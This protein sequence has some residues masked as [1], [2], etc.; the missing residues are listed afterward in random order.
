[1]LRSRFYGEG[2][3]IVTFLTRDFGKMSGIAKGA[4]K[5]K[6]RFV[7]SLEPFTHVHLAFRSRPQND[8]CFIESADIIRSARKLAFD[9]DRYAFSTYVV[10]IIDSM[11][12]GREAE[13]SLFDLAESTLARIDESPGTP[14]AMWL[15]YFE[16]KVLSLTGLEPRFGYC[17]RCQRPSIAGGGHFRFDPRA[18]AL[19]CEACGD[20]TGMAVSEAAIASMLLLQGDRPDELP[21]STRGEVRMLLQTFIGYHLRR[22][23]RSPALLREILE[24]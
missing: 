4:Q 16:T 14:D 20:G 17:N 1:V 5:S 2:D 24:A 18:G 8:L 12:E 15:R 6:R 11:V 3:K 19:A 22:P 13:A 23:L 9:L 10:E 7:A 21:S